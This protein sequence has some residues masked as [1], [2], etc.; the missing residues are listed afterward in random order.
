MCGVIEIENRRPLTATTRKKIMKTI[1]HLLVAVAAVLLASASQSNAQ[2][3]AVGD[4]GIAASPKYRQLLNE[5]GKRMVKG[6]P[7]TAVASVGYRATGRD[8]L[9]AS[10]KLRQIIDDSR[11]V[12]STGPTIDY[13]HAPRPTMSPKDPRFEAAWRAN[14]EREFQVAPV[15]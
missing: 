15:K 5:S 4:D 3:R 9:T 14:A 11:G 7:S 8:G 2:Y 10:P 13:A 12:A 1:K 6:S